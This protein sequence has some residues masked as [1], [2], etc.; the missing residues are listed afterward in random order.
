[1]ANLSESLSLA[2]QMEDLDMLPFPDWD[3]LDI[4]NYVNASGWG[5]RIG[6]DSALRRIATILTTRGCP[7]RCTFCSAHTVHGRKVRYRSA[8][9]VLEEMKVLYEKYRVTLFVP[10]DDL[11]TANRT[12]VLTLLKEIHNLNIPGIEM[13]FTGG[14]NV[15]TMDEEIL[16]AMITSGT[17]VVTLAIESGSEF[18]Q[19]HIIK[20][21]VDLNKARYLVHLC[22]EK[23]LIV[24]CNIILGFPGET[25]QLMEET[26]DYVRNLGADWYAFLIAAPL[27]GTEMY[28]QFLEK[29]YLKEDVYMWS[30]V[31]FEDRWFDTDEISAEGLKELTYR[32]NLDINFVNNINLRNGDSDRA[33]LLFNDIVRAYPF[34]IFGLYGLHKAYKGKGS[35]EEAERIIQT[36]RRLIKTDERAYNLYEKYSDIIS[37]SLLE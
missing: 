15:N 25:R 28:K 36:I 8:K 22:R 6:K 32:I 34:H 19:K 16:D 10:E 29:G 12:R 14:L 13:Q 5:R 30:S 18:V 4:E 27:I 7:F 31:G 20:K 23:G 37:E 33:I 1:M 17:R 2:E 26:V 21:N 24:R 11:F 35:I 3:L 9:N